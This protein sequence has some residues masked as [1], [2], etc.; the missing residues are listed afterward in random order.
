[1][2]FVKYPNLTVRNDLD[3]FKSDAVDLAV[4]VKPEWNRESLGTK[5]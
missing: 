4:K 1:M 3:H 2:S 5:V